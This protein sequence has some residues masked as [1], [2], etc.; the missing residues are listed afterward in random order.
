[1]IWVERAGQRKI[2]IG[3]KGARLKAIGSAARQALNELYGRR[4]HIHTWVKL[5]EGWSDDDRLLEQLGYGRP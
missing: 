2:V 5:R 4:V 1:V 3:A